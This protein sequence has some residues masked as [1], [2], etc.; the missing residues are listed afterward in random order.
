MNKLKALPKAAAPQLLLWPH[1]HLEEPI[2]KYCKDF[3]EKW[4]KSASVTSIRHPL[5]ETAAQKDGKPTGPRGMAQELEGCY[6]YNLTHHHMEQPFQA[7]C[8]LFTTNS[9]TQVQN[10]GAM[11]KPQ[12]FQN[13]AGHSAG[14]D[15][16]LEQPAQLLS[17]QA[18]L[19][20]TQ[21]QLPSSCD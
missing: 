4:S 13:T 6:S 11:C 15:K 10:G 17:P 1:W 5:A 8:S 14:Q 21:M 7:R 18:K 2:S 9:H 20:T 12:S 16:M 19:K 3:P